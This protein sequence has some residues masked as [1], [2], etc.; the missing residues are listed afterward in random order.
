MYTAKYRTSPNKYKNYSNFLSL[1]KCIEI[2]FACC[3]VSIE[4]AI[5][6]TTVMYTESCGYPILNTTVM[7]TE[8]CGYPI[9]MDINMILIVMRN[10][11]DRLFFYNLQIYSSVSLA[12][13][14]KLIESLMRL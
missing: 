9:L 8:S 1:P 4:K 5:R 11:G 6:N 7:Y 2:G 13:F 3:H 10:M 14:L 12:L